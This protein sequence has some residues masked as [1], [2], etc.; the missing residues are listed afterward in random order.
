ML[1]KKTQVKIVMLFSLVFIVKLCGIAAAIPAPQEQYVLGLPHKTDHIPPEY[2]GPAD[3][4]FPPSLRK[5]D[6]GPFPGVPFRP[7]NP[8]Q[9]QVPIAGDPVRGSGAI[10]NLHG[11]LTHRT[12]DHAGKTG[13]GVDEFALP[14]GAELAMTVLM[15][16]H[17]GRGPTGDTG[18]SG[19]G[20]ALQERAAREDFV[21]TGELAFVKQ[22]VYHLGR[23]M[24][25]PLGRQ[26]LFDRGTRDYYQY[27]DLLP[28]DGRK[29]VA[30]S[31]TQH[32]MHE[33]ARY[34]LSGFFGL[35]WEEQAR[36]DLQIEYTGINNTLAGYFACPK[37]D[38]RTRE[39][40]MGTQAVKTWTDIYLKD[41]AAR[42]N[43]MQLSGMTWTPA[44]ARYAQS[45]CAYETVALG[46]SPFCALFTFEE[47][48]G[49]EYSVDL[50]F[51]GNY[52]FGSPVGRASGAGWVQETLA[53]LEG[54][55]ITSPAAQV[56]VTLANNPD[57]FPLDQQLY[58]DFSHDATMMSVLAAFG[59][60][61]FAPILPADKMVEPR[62]V[63]VA[64]M[65]PFAA[66]LAIEHIRTPKP[67]VANRA[68]AAAN[69][70]SVYAADGEPTE[71]IHFTLNQRTIP[72]G[73]SIPACGDRDDGWC[74]FGAFMDFQRESL[75]KAQFDY[76]C[77]GNW[78]P[79]KYG[80]LT[81]GVPLA[82]A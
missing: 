75:E 25:T 32:R 48:E 26:E 71:Y 20:H 50:E 16:R 69:G 40:F 79:Y 59:L 64:E 33:S 9:T 68:E 81:D 60:R 53:R 57:T 82:E 77:H 19:F 3:P 29:L 24:L 10:F 67:V 37:S 54:R 70:S 7:A 27:A 62:E 80:D 73:K 44:D 61:Q 45:L 38:Y 76:S 5:S 28:K 12:L 65:F 55:Y 31:T 4:G 49:Y 6:P 47:W 56:N 11:Q 35:D 63:N 51:S 36:L 41:A 2:V 39:S 8:V 30:R 22:Y 52:G 78:G 14:H 1:L 18:V 23:E 46:Y 72:L 74:E 21:V 17:G 43:K 34:Y 15:Q 13:F 66:S 58:I 42:L